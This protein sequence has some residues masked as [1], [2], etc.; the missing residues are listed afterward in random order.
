MYIP[1]MGNIVREGGG[2]GKSAKSNISAH[3]VV[4]EVPS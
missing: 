1:H 4:C 3:V 2:G